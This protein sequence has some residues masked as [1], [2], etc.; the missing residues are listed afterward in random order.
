MSIIIICATTATNIIIIGRTRFS[1]RRA[2][3]CGRER[4]C[5]P[6][7]MYTSVLYVRI[8]LMM[9]RH[10]VS[11]L[12]ADVVVIVVVVSG[13]GGGGSAAAATV[14]ATAAASQSAS[15]GVPLRC[16]VLSPMKY[17]GNFNKRHL[18]RAHGLVRR[19]GG[20]GRYG[21]DG[22]NVIKSGRPGSSE[23]KRLVTRS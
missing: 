13:G 10:A 21:L 7:T 20:M 23:N 19:A 14:T 18:A 9:A 8:N 4:M 16:I 6:P 5:V 15:Q 12:K 11:S 22:F 3:V 2:C 17:G 1:S